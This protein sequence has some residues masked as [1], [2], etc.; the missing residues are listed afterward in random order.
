MA[1]TACCVLCATA[2][3]VLSEGRAMRGSQE[4][5]ERPSLIT[6]AGT[7]GTLHDGPWGQRFLLRSL[8]KREVC[9]FG[10]TTTVVRPSSSPATPHRPLA[11]TR[12]LL[13]GPSSVRETRRGLSLPTDCTAPSCA[14]RGAGLQ[15]HMHPPIHC[16]PPAAPPMPPP[17]V[18]M[19][20]PGVLCC[21][22]RICHP[23]H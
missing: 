5:Y 7:S 16:H 10:T 12:L 21:R 23:M 14:L 17:F 8:C 13:S 20:G 9:S 19:H 1:E 4:V 22:A 11:A 15:N 6:H 2:R 18:S 3:V